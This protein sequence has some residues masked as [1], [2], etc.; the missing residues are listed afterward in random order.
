MT[1]DMTKGSPTRL[2]LLFSIPLLIGNVFQQLYSMADTV[3]VGRVIG[4]QALAAVGSTGP[5]CFLVFGFFFGF[6]GGVT[7]ITGQRF[8]AKDHAGVRRSIAMSLILCGAMSLLVTIISL[9]LTGWM[10]RAMN[11]PTEIFDDAYCYLAILFF[12]IG[13]TVFYN[14]IASVI[15]AL[16]DS[17]TPLI[18]LV[19]ASVLNIALDFAFILWFGWGVAGVAWATVISQLASGWWCLEFARR[20]F[21]ELHLRRTDWHYD[22]SFAWLHLRIA[23]PMAFQFSVTAIGVIVMQAVLN[24]LGPVAVAAFTAGAKIDQLSIQPAFSLAMTIGTFVAQN[25]GA[26]DFERIRKGTTRCSV[27]SLIASVIG[28]IV[29]IGFCRELTILFVGSEQADIL[30]PSVRAFMWSCAPF[31]SVL[32]LLLIYRHALQGMGY[33]FVPLMAGVSEL[34]IRSIFAPVL[35]EYWGFVG[36]CLSNPLAWFGAAIPLGI[37]Y[38]RVIRRHTGNYL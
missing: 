2:I 37:F 35:G 13:A 23:L 27:I 17:R 15:R 8:G 4:W 20:K 25:Y 30:V 26:N 9:A 24:K 6:T 32:G 22:W 3:I 12:G 31:Y 29:V 36:V 10:L 1:H 7:V 5:L 28:M 34:F 19:I 16:G 38:F 33:G 18:F 21:P 14:W 11:T